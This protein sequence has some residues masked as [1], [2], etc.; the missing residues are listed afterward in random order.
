MASGTTGLTC[1]SHWERLNQ[2]VEARKELV[3]PARGH[4]GAYVTAVGPFAVWLSGAERRLE[5]AEPVPRTKEAL[6]ATVEESEVCTYVCVCVRVC[7]RVRVCACVHVCAC[8]CVCVCVCVR[9][10]VRVCA[11]VCV[12]VCVHCMCMRVHAKYVHVQCM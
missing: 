12:C 10:C 2:E 4:L 3:E 6:F 1:R 9:V 7:A 8:V 5:E 11:C